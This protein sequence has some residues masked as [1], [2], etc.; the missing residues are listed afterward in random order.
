MAAHQGGIDPDMVR[1]GVLSNW[2]KRRFDEA[3][4]T[5]GQAHNFHFFAGNFNKTV[6]DVDVLIQELKPDVVCIDGSYLMRPSGGNP[7][8]GRFEAAAYVVDEQK[9][10]ALMRERPV[11]CTTQF[12]RGAGKGGKDGSIETIGYTDTIG[13]HA[14][15]VIAAKMGKKV[16]KPIVELVEEDGDFESR[17]VGYKDVTPHRHLELLKGREGESGSFGIRYKFAPVDFSEVPVHIAL[18]KQEPAER[19]SMDYMT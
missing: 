18:G 2:A 13:T 6:E 5:L 14:S 16:S 11:V 4:V 12:G 8:M 17:V 9:R 7:R 15:I 19:P 1:K 10:M 3:L